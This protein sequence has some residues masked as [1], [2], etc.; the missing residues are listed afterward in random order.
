MGFRLGLFVFS[1]AWAFPDGSCGESGF[2]LFAFQ[3]SNR[4]ASTGSFWL[5]STWVSQYGFL[6]GSLIL[7][8][9]FVR[10]ILISRFYGFSNSKGTLDCL[11]FSFI[12]KLVHFPLPLGGNR[13]R[14]WLELS[15][16][17][18]CHSGSP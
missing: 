6:L 7:E 15:P 8:F 9:D 5:E 11:F 2:L 10:L 1:S 17:F 18:S 13:L 3:L 14:I 16:L 12:P 4:L